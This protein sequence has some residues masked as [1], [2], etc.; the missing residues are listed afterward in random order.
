MN[1]KYILWRKVETQLRSSQSG[2]I[3][4]EH[5][6]T[7]GKY[8]SGGAS[9]YTSRSGA[10]ARLKPGMVLVHV[11]ESDWVTEVNHRVTLDIDGL[12]DSFGDPHRERRPTFMSVDKKPGGAYTFRMELQE[13]GNFKTTQ[14]NACSTGGLIGSRRPSRIVSRIARY[15]DQ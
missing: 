8:T 15:G 6:E 12:G 10:E 4:V 14:P 13:N 3:A 9:H 7:G 11:V 2:Y 5:Y 1:K